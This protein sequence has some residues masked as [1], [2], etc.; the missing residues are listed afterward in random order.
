VLLGS[1][2]SKVVAHGKTAVLV[3]RGS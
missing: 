1:E 3:H 2:T